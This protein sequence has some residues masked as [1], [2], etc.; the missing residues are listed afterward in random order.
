MARFGLTMTPVEFN[1]DYKVL[2]NEKN[3][4]FRFDKSLNYGYYTVEVLLDGVILLYKRVVSKVDLLNGKEPRYQ[5]YFD[6]VNN[7]ETE[8]GLAILE[9]PDD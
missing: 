3:Y 1:K 6:N 8:Q 7:I 5:V 2:I 9:T 4:I